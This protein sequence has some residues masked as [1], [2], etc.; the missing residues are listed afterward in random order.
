MNPFLWTY[1]EMCYQL[2]E[3]VRPYSVV[4]VSELA[5]NQRPRQRVLDDEPKQGVK[6]RGKTAEKHGPF[7]R[8]NF[9][10]SFVAAALVQPNDPEENPY[11]GFQANPTHL[12][13][14]RNKSARKV[15]AHN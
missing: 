2:S 15:H 13:N 3:E 12:R 7:H 10:L 14:G 11:T 4:A 5:L 8:E 6:D 1:A 9:G